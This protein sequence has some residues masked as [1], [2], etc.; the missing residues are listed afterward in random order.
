MKFPPSPSS[1]SEKT[2]GKVRIKDVAAR[3]GVSV[4]TVSNVINNRG[5]VSA[6]RRKLVERAIKDLSFKGSLLAK[7][8]R[9]QRFPVVGLCVPNATSSNFVMM[10]DK[11]EA[12]ADSAKFELVQVVTR[13]DPE[14]EQVRIERLIASRASGVML[15]P[16]GPASHLIDRLV[17]EEMPT[18]A[19][20]HFGPTNLVDHVFVDH[21]AAFRDAAF[22]L[23]EGGYEALLV[24]SQFPDFAVVRQN[25]RGLEEGIEDA[26]G[27]AS[28]TV[29]KAGQT[30]DEFL[31]EFEAALAQRQ[32]RMAVV[33]SSSLLAA[34]SI[35]AFRV[36]GI[37]YPDQVGLL[38][39]EEPNWAKAI[40]PNL[41][42]ISQPSGELAQKTWQL[43]SAR[44][45]GNNEPPVTQRCEPM[46]N[47]RASTKL[48]AKA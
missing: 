18:V 10:S 24:I 8:M 38:C 16:S 5:N 4:G 34:W 40:W 47:L 37:D 45:A 27:H 17:E 3:A 35:E 12:H 48:L 21:R 22:Q 1:G 29:M 33:A 19:I 11:I 41:S 20:N 43:L 14:R 2:G 44:I 36:L 30:K 7:S 25:I 13:H 23:V 46:V 32:G 9:T 31:G 15:L 28:L 39:S 26:G 6:A 42:C